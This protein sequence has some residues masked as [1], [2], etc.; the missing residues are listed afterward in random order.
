MSEI[1]IEGADSVPAQPMLVLPNRVDLPTMLELE[2][3]LGGPGRVAWMVENTLMPGE[4]IMNHLRETRSPGFVCALNQQGRDAVVMKARQQL[5]RGRHVVLLPGR[6]LQ[7]PGNLTDLPASL[8]SLFDATPLHA[9]PV[10]V[11]MYN[12][13]F[14]A[15][16]TTREPYDRLHISFCTPLRA[17]SQLG[18]RVQAA[19]MRAQVGQLEQ[20]PMLEHVNLAEMLVEALLRNPKGR[21]IDGID[22]S[23]LCYRDILSAAVMATSVLEKHAA[24]A[25]MGIIL[26]PGK[27]AT[28]ANLAC[29]L[30]GITAVN[31]NYTATQEQFEHMVKQAELTRFITDTRFV[32][33]GLEKLET[34]QQIG[35]YRAESPRNFEPVR[36]T[37]SRA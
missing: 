17:G 32:N 21:L 22:D 36:A 11:G 3:A 27:L 12:N 23:T 8:L 14:D 18:T 6:P 13:Y 24:T 2:K 29:L 33:R 35:I 5:E 30:A 16:I 26:P 19:W 1:R 28:I 4:A 7:A 9:M 31:I 25:R 34:N 20:L 15:A 37:H 10:Y